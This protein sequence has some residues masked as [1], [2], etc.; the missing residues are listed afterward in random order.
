M[1][2]KFYADAGGRYIG[3]VAGA[4][5]RGPALDENGDPVIDENGDPVTVIIPGQYDAPVPPPGGT[6]VPAP[7]PHAAFYSWDGSAWVEDADRADREADDGI[8][9]AFEKSKQNRLL[10]GILFEMVNDIRVLKGQGTI[11]KAQYRT[12]L[13][14]RWK[15]L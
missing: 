3:G 14:T 15:A 10:L 9:G 13:E 12:A 4:P 8:K 1:A 7:P 11:T 6:E 5:S 2:T